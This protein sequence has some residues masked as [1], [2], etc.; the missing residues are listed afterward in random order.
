MKSSRKSLK[1]TRIFEKGVDI[2]NIRKF[3][4]SIYPH[5][6]KDTPEGEVLDASGDKERS[7]LDWL[8][9]ILVHLPKYEKR[10]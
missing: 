1:K 7:L 9:D 4:N 2:R 8:K 3:S 10:S 5:P 6:T